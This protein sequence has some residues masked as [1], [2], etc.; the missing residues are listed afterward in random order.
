LQTENCGSIIRGGIVWRKIIVAEKREI[1]RECVKKELFTRKFD[2][3]RNIGVKNF[4]KRI[5]I[6]KLLGLV[7]LSRI[8]KVSYKV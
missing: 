1:S 2:I 4:L 8:E 5:A 6:E 7:D 3:R